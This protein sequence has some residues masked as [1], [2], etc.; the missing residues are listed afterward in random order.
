MDESTLTY[1]ILS[2]RTGVSETTIKSYRRKFPEFFPVHSRGKPIRFKAVAGETCARIREC[3]GRDMSVQDIREDLSRKFP[4]LAAKEASGGRLPARESAPA[5]GPGQ[6]AVLEALRRLEKEQSGINRKL[7]KLL[8][9]VLDLPARDKQAGPSPRQTAKAKKKVRVRDAHGD[10]SE[11]L[12]DATGSG[13][14]RVVPP[15]EFLELPLVVQ[16]TPDEF[17][18]VAG[19]AFGPFSLNALLELAKHASPPD[20]YEARWNHLDPGWELSLEQPEAERPQ[21]HT[22]FIQRIRT[23][24]GNLVAVLYR[25]EIN[26]KDLPP[27]N[28]YAFIK[29]LTD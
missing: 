16:T 4:E 2:Q 17:L 19:K 22:L 26:G 11:Y 21:T 3:F 29:Q 9:A 7:D 8:D 12:F 28:L 14:Q 25:F 13:G 20:R 24:R 15:G 1:K 27:P 5:S 23:P 10:A 6:K 18:G